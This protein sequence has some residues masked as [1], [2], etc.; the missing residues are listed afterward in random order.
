MKTIYSFLTALVLVFA[1]YLP[2]SPNNPSNYMQ[3]VCVL[4]DNMDSSSG[5][6]LV[7]LHKNKTY[8]L[9][10]AH[11]MNDFFGIYIPAYVVQ[12]V[13]KNEILSKKVYI[14]RVVCVDKQKDL[15]LLEITG[16]T[17][18]KNS[19]HINDES[20][21]SVG[22]QIWTIGSHYG[23]KCYNTVSRGIISRYD[24]GKILRYQIDCNTYLGVSGGGMFDDNGRFLGIVSSMRNVNMGYVITTKSVK[25]FLR[26]NC[27]EL[28]KGNG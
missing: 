21:V 20:Y 7:I 27:P 12:N 14:G 23:H 24:H 17:H 1:F 3:S 26:K 16:K 5:S 2:V 25:Q 4:I 9:T 8:I 13:Y 28:L 10:C 18:F 11:V 15:A 6:G 22:N 19:I